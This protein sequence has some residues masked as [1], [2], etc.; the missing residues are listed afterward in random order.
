MS[1]RAILSR[2]VVSHAHEWTPNNGISIL[3]NRSRGARFTVGSSGSTS[4]SVQVALM[5][6][7][8][9]P[10]PEVYAAGFRTALDT[11]VR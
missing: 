11:A 7:V 1:H 9:E 6:G 5:Y 3:R 4:F 8:M 10:G 2:A